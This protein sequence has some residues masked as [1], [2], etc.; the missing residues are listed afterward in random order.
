[1]LECEE[2]QQRKIIP[3]F[4]RNHAST[5][6]RF[7][8]NT[9]LCHGKILRLMVAIL[10]S[11]EGLFRLTERWNCHGNLWVIHPK[12]SPM[13]FHSL[14][15][16]I[17][18]FHFSLNDFFPSDLKAYCKQA[19]IHSKRFPFVFPPISFI[20]SPPTSLNW[21]GN[22]FH[23]KWLKCLCGFLS[24]RVIQCDL[25]ENWNEKWEKSKRNS[26]FTLNNPLISL[27]CRWSRKYLWNQLNPQPS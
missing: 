20:T 2:W 5:L 26:I 17:M 23:M 15:C 16:L 4:Q 14:D 1:M 8:L 11:I 10:K 3:H 25:L 21:Y 19:I 24:C 7:H 9:L 22:E 27:K 13:M 12:S 18:F 6:N